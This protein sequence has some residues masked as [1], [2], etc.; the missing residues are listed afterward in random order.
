ML[1][2]EIRNFQAKQAELKAANPAGGFVAIKGEE[3]LGVWLNRIDAIQQAVA[4]W[5]NTSF[6]V[7][8]INDDLTRV[9]T[10]SRDLQFSNVV[11][12]RAK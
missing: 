9:F 10:F 5:G 3:I 4:K 7:K 12:L 6:L 11:S 1:Q 2:K 8:N